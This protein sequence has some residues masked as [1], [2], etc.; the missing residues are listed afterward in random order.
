[1]QVV[2]GSDAKIEVDG[3]V[4]IENAIKFCASG[5]SILGTA[6]QSNKEGFSAEDIKRFKEMVK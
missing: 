1:M 4:S 6:M 2:A 3:N 5:A